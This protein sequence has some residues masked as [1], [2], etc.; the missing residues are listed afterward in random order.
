MSVKSRQYN[1][2]KKHVHGANDPSSDNPHAALKHHAIEPAKTSDLEHQ[3]NQ[4]SLT[5]P[6]HLSLSDQDLFDTH[7]GDRQA[8]ECFF[9]VKT[10]MFGGLRTMLAN[11][12]E[13]IIRLSQR[14]GR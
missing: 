10:G 8:L 2:V 11:F 13:L 6:S 3:I 4:V 9:L 5:G 12:L 1:S 14:I 7:L